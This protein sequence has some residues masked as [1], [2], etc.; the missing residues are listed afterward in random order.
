MSQ[1]EETWDIIIKPQSKWYDLRLNQLLAYKDL[2]FLFVRRDFVSVYKQTILG[3]LWFFF[4]PLVTTFTFT[5]I[6]GQ[7]AGIPTDGMPPLLF[8][9]S[10]ITLWNYFAESLT[11]TS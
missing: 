10:G 11:K 7:L 2:L 8:Y 9:L 5:L 1:T 4:Q 3:P 6:F